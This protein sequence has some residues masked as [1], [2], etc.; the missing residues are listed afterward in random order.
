MWRRYWCLTN[1]FRLSIHAFA[2]IW[3]D[4]VVRRYSDG[5][6]C[7]LYFQRAAC[8]SFQTC[9]LSGFLLRTRAHI[10]KCGYFFYGYTELTVV[11]LG[12]RA[13]RR[14]LQKNLEGMFPD[15]VVALTSL[16]TW[17]D[18][19]W[20]WDAVGLSADDWW[21]SFWEQTWTPGRPGRSLAGTKRIGMVIHWHDLTLCA[22]STIHAVS[23][24]NSSLP[25][26]CACIMH[27][28]HKFVTAS[29]LKTHGCFSD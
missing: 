15:V 12:G 11:R 8:T 19:L 13:S 2:K 25:P 4:K 9:I 21:N 18:K 17:R 10:V 6:F 24:L 29:L 22:L 27:L 14:M 7:V 28:P 26:L 20:H 1:L 3:P 5:D 23:H 16:I